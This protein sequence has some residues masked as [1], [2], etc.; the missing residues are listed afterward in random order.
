MIRMLQPDIMLNERLGRPFDFRCSEQCLT[1]REGLW[2][3]C[4]TVGTNSWGWTANDEYKTSRQ[5]A[6]SLVNAA[7]N[8]GNLLLNIGP[9]ADGTIDAGMSRPVMEVGDWLRRNPGWLSNSERSPFSWFTSGHLTVK[10]SSVFCHLFRHADDE[11]CLAEIGNN[12]KEVRLLDGGGKLEFEQRGGRLLI[13]GLAGLQD[14]IAT[15][16]E[17]KVEGRPLPFI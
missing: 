4:I 14:P 16:L 1:P 10:G 17:I 11:L 9:K 13:K 12:V 3:S 5:L 6:E 15:V 8:G 2:E 7:K